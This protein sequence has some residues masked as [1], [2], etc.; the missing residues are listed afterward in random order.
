M[1]SVTRQLRRPLS[2]LL[3][4]DIFIPDRCWDSRRT[5]RSRAYQARSTIARLLAAGYIDG[6]VKMCSLLI[7]YVDLKDCNAWL[8]ANN[9]EVRS[10][11]VELLDLVRQRS[12]QPRL[13][14]VLNLE[15]RSGRGRTLHSHGIAPLWVGAL[16]KACF[17]EKVVLTLPSGRR[18]R[19]GNVRPLIGAE[20]GKT[21]RYLNKCA[22]SNAAHRRGQTHE[23][24][25]TDV[26][27]AM[28]RS[29][30]AEEARRQEGLFRLPSTRIR[31]DLPRLPKL[32]DRQSKALAEILNGEVPT[33][34]AP[35]FLAYL[36]RVAD[37]LEAPYAR[38][39]QE[40]LILEFQARSA[41]LRDEGQTRKTPKGRVKGPKTPRKPRRGARKKKA[42]QAGRIVRK[43]KTGQNR[44][45]PVQ[46]RPAK[47]QSVAPAP[48]GVL[49]L[50]SSVVLGVLSVLAGWR[51]WLAAA[52]LI[53]AL[54]HTNVAHHLRPADGPEPTLTFRGS[55]GSGR[56]K[57]RGTRAR[58]PP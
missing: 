50:I 34:P 28:G 37:R 38:R 58:E 13:P 8:P 41:E 44:E 2:R 27:Q 21:W 45:R 1:N 3:P 39:H 43:R 51:P 36:D 16:F 23:E 42:R 32:T 56:A 19:I 10:I 15:R 12:G 33:I 6:Y 54:S 55:A 4:G 31:F 40:R 53:V 22:D 14:M 57:R 7:E 17:G 29:Q 9:R 11:L 26:Q 52:L 47:R 49:I 46:K 25:I 35:T 18:V 48:G 5:S 20:L 30:E 24:W